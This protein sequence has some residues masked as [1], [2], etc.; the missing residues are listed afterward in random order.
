MAPNRPTSFQIITVESHDGKMNNCVNGRDVPTYWL[1]QG[2]LFRIFLKRMLP[3]QESLYIGTSLAVDERL[4]L[5]ANVRHILSNRFKVMFRTF[6]QETQWALHD[7][8][9][10]EQQPKWV[11]FAKKKHTKID[12]TLYGMFA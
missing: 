4:I 1:I 7:A 5:V 11:N 12:T 10:K 6:F 8:T 9:L 2:Y 3:C